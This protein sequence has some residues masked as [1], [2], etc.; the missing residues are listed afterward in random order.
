MKFYRLESTD[1]IG[2]YCRD[3]FNER[4]KAK[5]V[6]L[7]LY[8]HHG[9]QNES[10]P[11]LNDDF[12]NVYKMQGKNFLFACSSL[13]ALKHWFDDGL[14]ESL[15]ALRN[16]NVMVYDSTKHIK[17][18]SKIQYI[19]VPDITPTILPKG[20]IKKLLAI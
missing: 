13:E 7:E 2:V 16:V 19:F 4:T 3:A 10:R 8:Q 14:F 20:K 9:W 15:V 11:N 12:D 17:G 5:E 1:G 18:K 6:Q